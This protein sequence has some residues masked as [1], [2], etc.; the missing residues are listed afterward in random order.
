MDRDKHRDR[1]INNLM[2]FPLILASAINFLQFTAVFMPL[3]VLPVL[4]R[5]LRASIFD[6]GGY[7]LHIF[8]MG[9]GSPTR[10]I[11]RRPR[12]MSISLLKSSIFVLTCIRA[13]K[14]L[15]QA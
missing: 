3:P 14:R 5:Q 13:H 6:V 8:C 12:E 10:E 4:A 1:K 7:K 15:Y 9:Q 11:S 2:S